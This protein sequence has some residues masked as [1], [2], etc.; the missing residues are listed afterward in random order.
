MSEQNPG[1]W[2]T[3]GSAGPDASQD[4]QGVP[5]LTNPAQ[6]GY[7]QPPY[8]HP[9]S[10]GQQGYG[11]QGYGQAPY[12][13]PPYTQQGYGPP[14]YGRTYPGPPLRSDYTH[15][16]RRVGAYVIDFLPAIVAQVVFSIGYGIWIADVA[17]QSG[18][19]TPTFDGPA[20]TTMI[21]GTVLSLVALGWQIYNRW[22]LAGRTGQSVG[23]RVLKIFLISDETGRPIGVLNAFLRDL[24]HILD[25][26]AYIGYLWPLWDEKRQTFADKL[27]RTIV[28]GSRTQS[29][30]FTGQAG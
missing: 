4:R 14:A 28:V 22:V 9:T 11:Q 12:P 23:K 27:M 19:E 16:G 17:S 20:P 3:H 30:T 2:Q 13:Q 25:G 6:P 10:Y 8:G 21:V 29:A 15:W 26:F 1:P 5:P 7:G 18:S 24:V